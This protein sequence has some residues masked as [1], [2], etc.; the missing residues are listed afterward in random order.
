M[1]LTS[2]CSLSHFAT[3]KEQLYG[4]LE[5]MRVWHCLYPFQ[6]V[7]VDEARIKKINIL[8]DRLITQ[9]RS[10]TKEIETKKRDLNNK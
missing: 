9:G 5:V 3:Y 2:L 7:T 8:G 4:D 6:D 10:D 1:P